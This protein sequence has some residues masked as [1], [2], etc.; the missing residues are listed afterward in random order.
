M[1]KSKEERIDDALNQLLDR[2]LPPSQDDPDVDERYYRALDFARDTLARHGNPETAADV[3][4]VGDLIKRKLVRENGSA[5]PALHFGNLF[6]RLLSQPV[7]N[8]KSAILQLLYKLSNTSKPTALPQRRTTASFH[9]KL[10]ALRSNRHASNSPRVEHREQHVFDQAFARSGLP[11]QPSPEKLRHSHTQEA[12]TPGSLPKSRRQPAYEAVQEDT[13]DEQGANHSAVAAPAQA[14]EATLL[15]DLPFTL[16]GVSSHHLLFSDSHGVLKMP[17]NMPSP[18][19]SLLHALAEPSLLYRRL[20]IFVESPNEGLIGQSLRS[21]LAVELRSYLSL[22]GTLESQIRRALASM[23]EAPTRRSLGQAG[24]TLKRMVVWTRDATMGLR[25][26]SLIVEESQGAPE[27]Q[28]QVASMKAKP[29]TGTQAPARRGGQLISL[30]HSL[31]SSHGDPFVGRFADRLLSHVTQ[32]LYDML[33]SW[34]YDGELA[35]PYGEFFVS[36]RHDTDDDDTKGRATSVW[37]DKY[38]LVRGMIPS[39]MTEEFA[40]KVFLIGKSLNFIR[41]GCGDSGWVE[42]YSKQASR[43]LRYGDTATLESS[44]DEAY[45]TTMARL[46]HLMNDKFHLQAHL[47]ALKKYL[48]LGQGDFIALLMESLASN[49]DRPANSQYRHTLTAQLEHAIRN[50]N[51]QYDDADVLRRLDARMLELSHG[52]VGWDVFTLEYK[53]DAPVDVVVTA[54]N[55]RRYLAVFNMLWRIKRVEYALG[56]T[57]RRCMAGARGVL[58]RVSDAVGEE[59][60]GAHCALGEMTHFITQLQWYLLFEVIEKAWSEL[61]K[62]CEEPETTLDDLV[63]AHRQYLMAITNKGLLGESIYHF[64]SQLHELLKIM[65]QYRE[66]VDGLYSYSVSEQAR[67]QEKSARIERRTRQGRW[68]MSEREEGAGGEEGDDDEAGEDE[69]SESEDGG[70]GGGRARRRRGEVEHLPTPLLNVDGAEGD[71]SVLGALR[72]RLGA[73]SSD[74]RAKVSVLLG[75]LAYQPDQDMRFLGTMVNFN[76]AYKSV[77]RARRPGS[78]REKKKEKR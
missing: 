20:A 14:T 74:F 44:I 60:K 56:T 11:A 13:E 17:T 67:R 48:L 39:I 35:D 7:L 76:N 21:A 62:R 4:H 57:W 1:P 9:E 58:R 8:H 25:L 15:R 31:A 45:K 3:S 77:R 2:H 68:G 72:Q 28:G 23:G 66:A 42:Q 30:I 51:A 12:N 27:P 41:H 16:Q 36:E 49:L 70:H 47:A 78:E 29:A 43:E 10:D 64:R 33:R 26:L 75:D 63:E 6:E 18:V 50:S 32:P 19:I 37:E 54:S 71:G 24:V 34:I 5:D 38:S 46:I 40:G 65:L 69:E 61:Q 55:A 53:I 59:W 22:V 73:L 52:D